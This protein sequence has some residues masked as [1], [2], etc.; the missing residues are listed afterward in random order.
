[1]KRLL[2]CILLLLTVML[3]QA[4]QTVYV[5]KSGDTLKKIARMY[6]I[7]KSDIISS[8]PQAANGIYAGM[9]LYLPT[10]QSGKDKKQTDKRRQESE[11]YQSEYPNDYLPENSYEYH[12]EYPTESTSR[13][14]NT[15]V[16]YDSDYQE[17]GSTSIHSGVYFDTEDNGGIEFG[18]L[19]D[20]KLKFDMIQISLGFVFDNGFSIRALG[21]VTK[22]DD[23][24][25]KDRQYWFLGLGY[26]ARIRFSD[27][28]F[29]D[30]RPTIYYNHYSQKVASGSETKKNNYYNGKKDLY[31]TSTVWKEDSKDTYGIMIEPRFAIEF[32]P[33]YLSFGYCWAF[34][35]FKTD[36]MNKSEGITLTI[37][38]RP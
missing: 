25:I 7:S 3:M 37:G 12:A 27:F 30:L 8:N 20:N 38:W 26:N 1:M 10:S 17:G 6:N 21:D 22:Y 16:V 5:V 34:N 13:K 33:I 23:A 15:T 2:S 31:Y 29:L 32:N 9:E 28:A 4:Q 24:G 36:K 11:D 19:T 14:V 35:E 18:V